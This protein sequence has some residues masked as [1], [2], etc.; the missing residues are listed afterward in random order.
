[1]VVKEILGKSL[2][3]RAF[4]KAPGKAYIEA[5]MKGQAVNGFA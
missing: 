1:M 2:L 3:E 5:W 4:G